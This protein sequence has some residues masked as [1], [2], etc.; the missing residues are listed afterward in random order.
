MVDPVR[1]GTPDLVAGV[2][3]AAELIDGVYYQLVKTLAA[4][5]AV[6]V[7]ASAGAAFVPLSAG[8]CKAVYI[9]NN[10][11]D[12]VDLEVRRGASGGTRIVPADTWAIMDAI[13]D[14]SQIQIRRLDGLAPVLTVT[15]ELRT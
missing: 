5:S 10:R 9:E 14:A 12:A 2:D 3:A 4:T 13:T 8:V 11:L 7:N 15:T 1:L 6:L